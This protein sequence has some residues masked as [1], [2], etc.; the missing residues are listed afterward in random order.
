MGSG[1]A[2]NADRK[3]SCAHNGRRRTPIDVTIDGKPFTTFMWETNQRKPVLYPLIAPDGTTVTRG[4]PFHMLPGERVDHPHHAGLWFNYGNA[5]EF[6]FWNNSDA[7]K[8]A[9]RSKYGTVKLDKVVSSKSG[10]NSGELVTESTWIAGDPAAGN[11]KPIM[12]QTTRYVFS[13]TRS[14]GQPARAVDLVVT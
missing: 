8:P 13:K 14:R 4:Y 3:R 12:T 7:I 9:D 6:D 2:A 10:A 5:N 11:T 1:L